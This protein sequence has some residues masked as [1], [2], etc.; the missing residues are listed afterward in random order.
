[1]PYRQALMADLLSSLH[2]AVDD[3]GMSSTHTPDAVF[4]WVS[5]NS[6]DLVGWSPDE[7]IGRPAYEFLHPD[8]VARIE[9]SAA[10]VNQ[11]GQT[12]ITY[13]FRHK[14]GGW[15]WLETVSWGIEDGIVA[16]TRPTQPY[17]PDKRVAVEG[18]EPP[19]T[20]VKSQPL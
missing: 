7:L 19:T 17:D 14:N 5:R 13:R 1:M 3:G 2:D 18:L 20:L 16:I 15:V 4:T 8:D 6:R 10:E 11:G 12:V 9:Q